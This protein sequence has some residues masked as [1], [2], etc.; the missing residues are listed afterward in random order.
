MELLERGVCDVARSV[1]QQYGGCT[2]IPRKELGTVLRKVNG[3]NEGL[4]TSPTTLVL[5]LRFQRALPRLVAL[6]MVGWNSLCTDAI[7]L[8]ALHTPSKKPREFLHYATCFP[9]SVSRFFERIRDA[10]HVRVL[11]HPRSAR[12]QM[13]CP[14]LPVSTLKH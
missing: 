10:R 7:A 12:S 4:K 2:D 1:F 5:L 13:L 8:Q 3:I 11:L 6:P 9:A 14:S